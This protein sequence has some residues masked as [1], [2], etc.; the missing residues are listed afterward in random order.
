[1]RVLS[2]RTRCP[3]HAPVFFL[4][5]IDCWLDE[6]VLVSVGGSHSFHHWLADSA[7]PVMRTNTTTTCQVVVPS[8]TPG[9]AGTSYNLGAILT[10]ATAMLSTAQA[11]SQLQTRAAARVQPDE[12]NSDN[13]RVHISRVGEFTYFADGFG[14]GLPCCSCANRLLGV[15]LSYRQVL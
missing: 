8:P 4:Q 5:Q 10:H 14:L 7:T 15:S 6:S 9:E 1:M 3:K 2:R 11:L 13:E 12:H